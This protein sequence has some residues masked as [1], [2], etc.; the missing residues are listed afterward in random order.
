MGEILLTGE[1]AQEGATLLRIVVTDRAAQHGI[2]RLEGVEDRALRHR[3]L[4][5]ELDLAAGFGQRSQVLRE[6]DPDRHFNV[7]TSTES[8]AG[9]SRTIAFQLSP[10][11]LD[12]YTCPPLVP[13][14]TPHLSSES[15]A[16][17]SRRT[18]T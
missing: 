10:A 3:A 5:F 7:C 14:Y 9:R 6:F 12:A 4:D 15:T 2:S 8:T 1:E 17:A 13:K 18:F 16:M 11:S